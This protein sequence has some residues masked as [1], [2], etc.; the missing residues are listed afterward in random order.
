MLQSPADPSVLICDVPRKT[1]KF[2]HDCHLPVAKV[3]GGYLIVVARH[4]GE[5]H[6]V[7]ISL[8]ELQNLLTTRD[9]TVIESARKVPLQPAPSL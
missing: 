9:S 3:E 4:H 6:A 2:G 7:R 1:D 8:A 5:R